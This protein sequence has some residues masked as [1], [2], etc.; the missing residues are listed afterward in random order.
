MPPSFV[1]LGNL[2]AAKDDPSIALGNVFNNLALAR[3]TA[4]FPCFVTIATLV[5]GLIALSIVF[6][7]P[8]IAIAILEVSVVALG[9]VFTLS[10]VAIAVL[11]VSAVALGI[12]FTFPPV[13]FDALEVG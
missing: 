6:P 5:V 1:Q 2:T 4:R 11:I 9:I 8:P 12:V 10:P 7:L 13:A 3:L